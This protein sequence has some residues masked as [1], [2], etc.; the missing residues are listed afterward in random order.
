MTRELRVIV[1]LTEDRRRFLSCVVERLLQPVRRY[2]ITSM[3]WDKLLVC[4]ER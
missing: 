1:E 4:V 2:I 3:P